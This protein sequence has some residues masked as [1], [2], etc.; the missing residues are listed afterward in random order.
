[1]NAKK[2]ISWKD[3]F[4]VLEENNF[5]PKIVYT[6][7]LSFLIETE[8]KTFPNK[9]KLKKLMTIKPALWKIFKGILQ[10]VEELI[11]N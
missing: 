11:L 9:H 4:E 1:M 5:Q 10:T 6:A 8:I 7:K 2:R 3:I